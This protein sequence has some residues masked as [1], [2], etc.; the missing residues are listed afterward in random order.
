MSGPHVVR[1][2]LD[3]PARANALDADTVE[4]LH[5]ELAA[6]DDAGAHV[7]VISAHG[8]VFCSGLDLTDL[9]VET[10][11]TLLHRLVRVHLLLERVRDSR[12]LV[13]ALVQGPTVGAGADLVL[14]AHTR[15]A[16]PGA[17]LRFPGAGFGAVLGTARLAA[18]T[19]A[20]YA[21][22]LAL[23][24][25]SVAR[26]EAALRGI[27]RPVGSAEDAEREIRGLAEAAALLPRPTGARLRAAAG[28]TPAHDALGDLVRSLASEPGLAD[29]VRAYRARTSSVP[30]PSTPEGV[31]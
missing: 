5:E 29:R 17:G 7:V 23:T 3:R 22:D 12:C 24:G 6:A 10:D 26:D 1:L 21:A 18:E 13:V 4:R 16:L 2:T 27:W 14:A 25:R 31:R 9:A 30:E 8:R 28:G 11:A 15:L 19:S 20:S